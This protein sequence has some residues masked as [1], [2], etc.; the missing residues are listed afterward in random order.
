MAIET[1]DQVSGSDGYD[2]VVIGGGAA[3]LSGALTL[4]RARRSVLVVDAGA[5][6]NA[7]ADGVH[8]YL[9][10]EGTPPADLLAAGRAEVAGYG[11]QIMSGSVTTL[12]R[13]DGAD[14]SPAGGPR[15][16]VGLADGRTLLA[17]RLLVATGLVDELPD[18]PGLADRWGRDVVHCP[19]CHGWEL[20]DQP[21]GILATGPLAVHQALLWRQLTADVVLF[22]HTSPPLGDEQAEQLAARGIRVVDG[23]VAGLEVTD[24]RLTG[25]RLRS[26]EVVARRAVAVGTRMVSRADLLAPLGLAPVELR[27]G[28]FVI[29]SQIEADPMGAT[30]VPGVWVAGN[31]ASAQAQVLVSAAAGLTAGAAI[32]MDLVTEDTRVAL[33]A[34]RAHRQDLVFGPDAWDA[35]HRA[36]AE[37]HPGPD[38]PNPVLVEQIAALPAGTVLDAGAGTGADAGWLADRGWKV[39]AVDLSPAALE[40]AARHADRQGHGITWR[41]ADLA[42][43]PAP[44]TFDLVVSHYLCLP[45]GPR[46]ALFANLA[47]AVAAG[48]TLLLVGHAPA[49]GTSAPAQAGAGHGHGDR[50][51]DRRPGA[52]DPHLAEV[53]WSAPEV[54]ATL[55]PDWII[56]IAETRPFRAHEHHGA[57]THDSVLRARRGPAAAA[58]ADG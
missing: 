51:G 47:A 55:G 17:R 46:R 41:R 56:E 16:E 35:R 52:P 26:G 31:V 45:P 34:H 29:G 4:A 20:R 22:R 12:A 5:P 1:A 15:F 28:E 21:V 3:G 30:A 48:G 25:V 13:I 50:H 9:G 24:D 11:G 53:A 14:L 2:V 27:L 32:N 58:L 23:E 44:G 37:A 10:R 43:E 49:E 36:R 42:T 8:N 6:R 39:T 57:A 38:R 18:V 33:D 19:Y 54:A 40:A 7:P